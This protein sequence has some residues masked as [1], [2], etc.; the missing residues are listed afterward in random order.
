MD[1]PTEAQTY[2]HAAD[3]LPALRGRV[4]TALRGP[5]AAATVR[6]IEA[7]EA[8]ERIA[9][10][11]PAPDAPAPREIDPIIVEQAFHALTDAST[12]LRTFGTQ[13]RPLGP[14]ERHRAAVQD[15]ADKTSAAADALAQA[16]RNAGYDIVPF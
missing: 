11:A 3:A 10:R 16:S 2:L 12:L 15:L 1:E 4:V 6:A 8:A 7:L 14:L 9:D 5:D 13:G